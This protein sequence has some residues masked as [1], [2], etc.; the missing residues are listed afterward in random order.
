MQF[1]EAKLGE[2]RWDM[3]EIWSKLKS[4]KPEIVDLTIHNID[5]EKHLGNNV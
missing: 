4:L 5:L 2:T 3:D 1:V